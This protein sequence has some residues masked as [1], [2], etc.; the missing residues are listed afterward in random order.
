MILKLRQRISNNQ[1]GFTMVELLVAMAVASII[2]VAAG[3]TI[4]QVF[5]LNTRTSNHMI[6]V[7]QVQ[8][9]GYWVSH[10]AQMAQVRTV[11]GAP[12]LPFS[13]IWTD[14]NGNVDNVTYSIVGKA[15][16]RRFIVSGSSPSDTT[17]FVAQSIDS[18]GT[19]CTYNLAS[20]TFTFT[21]TATVGSGSRAESETRKYEVRPRSSP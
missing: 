21:V 16:K 14:W 18:G 13:L 12:G 4:S 1:K 3:T 5:N 15:L 2:A 10:D 9:A 8:T 6:A 11:P 20:N 7:R 17:S 19:S